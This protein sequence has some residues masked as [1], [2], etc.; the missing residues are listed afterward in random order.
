[1]SQSIATTIVARA[2]RALQA[3]GYEACPGVIDSC[4][5]EVEVQ[6]PVIVHRGSVRSVEF[7]TVV[8]RTNET[9]GLAN[10]ERFIM[11]RS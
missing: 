11:A 9:I 5:G 3:A 2:L 7:K 10:V 8:L 6:D 4:F 1:M